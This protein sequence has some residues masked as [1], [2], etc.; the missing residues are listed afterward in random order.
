LGSAGWLPTEPSAEK[1]GETLEET[2]ARL[3]GKGR[4]TPTRKERETARKRDP[5]GHQH[6]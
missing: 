5:G 4:A 3:A 1:T 6:E 2:A